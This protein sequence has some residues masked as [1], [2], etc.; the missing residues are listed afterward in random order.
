MGRLEI[1]TVRSGFANQRFAVVEARALVQKGDIPPSR[2]ALKTCSAPLESSTEYPR[3]S[4]S[5]TP[6]HPVVLR[7]EQSIARLA[8]QAVSFAWRRA[9]LHS[10]RFLTP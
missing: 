3:I 9:T 10:I 5:P 2:A 8:S 7:F 4:A 1:I 6:G